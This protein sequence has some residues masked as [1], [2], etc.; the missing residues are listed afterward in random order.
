[1]I[2]INKQNFFGVNCK[3]YFSNKHRKSDSSIMFSENSELI[4]KKQDVVNIFNYYF[5]SVVEN[6]R[7]FQWN[8]YN[9]EIHSKNVET[10]VKNF[11]NY[12][13]C[14]I[15]KKH[16]KNH[17]KFIFRYVTTDDVKNVILDFKNNKAA[18]SEI[19]VK[20]LK[21]CGFKFDTL[22]YCSNQSIETCNFPDC[23]KTVNI[24]PIFKNDDPIDKLNNRPVSTLPLLLKVYEKLLYNQLYKF[25]KNILNSIIF[26]KRIVHNMH[27]LSYSW[28]KEIDNHDFLGTMLVDL[29]K[30][31]DCICHEILIAKLHA[32]ALNYLSRRN[33]MTRTGSSVSTWFHVIAGVSQQSL[34]LFNTF[35]NDLLLFITQS[36]VYDIA[37]GITLYSCNKNL[38]V[39]FQDSLYNLKNVLNWF[40]INSLKAN[41]TKFLVLSRSISNSYILNFDFMKINVSIDNKLTFKKMNYAG[42]HHT[43]FTFCAV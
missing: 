5:G 16:F 15:I 36:Q 25:A 22:K 34:I 8:E 19:P 27:Y 24:T 12:P 4:T 42:Q 35:I 2:Q 38:S 20:I 32:Y 21:I 10:I 1:M 29:L 40:K 14:R 13:S 6:L 23:L 17:I 18:S 3:P 30:A 7:L 33:Q 43:K 28:Q 37:D 11:K 26:E 9:G 39:I 31:C 41:P